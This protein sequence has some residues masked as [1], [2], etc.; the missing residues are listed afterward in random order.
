MA[1]SSIVKLYLLVDP[2][3]NLAVYCKFLVREA[4]EHGHAS[5]ANL[6]PHSDGFA[7]S[8]SGSKSGVEIAGLNPGVKF[9]WFKTL[10]QIP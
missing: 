3:V 4:S 8:G 7:G 5:V 1:K 10:V 6:T 9:V 2:R